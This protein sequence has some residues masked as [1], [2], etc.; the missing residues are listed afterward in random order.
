[1]ESSGDDLTNRKYFP[2]GQLLGIYEGLKESQVTCISKL[3]FYNCKKA[4]RRAAVED[5]NGLLAHGLLLN[6]DRL[7]RSG[8]A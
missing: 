3:K 5:R 8:Q 2:L 1:M 4:A 6:F 7:R